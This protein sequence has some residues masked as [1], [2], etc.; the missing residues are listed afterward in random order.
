M[1]ISRPLL[2][3]AGVN[4]TAVM[5]L[6]PDLEAPRTALA[7]MGLVTVPAMAVT[8]K[9][10]TEAAVT[11][12]VVTTPTRFPVARMMLPRSATTLAQELPPL[13][14]PAP[15]FWHS[16]Q[17]CFCSSGLIVS[18]SCDRRLYPCCGIYDAASSAWMI[19]FRNWGNVRLRRPGKGYFIQHLDNALLRRTSE[20]R[21]A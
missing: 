15:W 7:V 19:G 16:E 5:G 12:A 11:E 1:L 9:A 3:W 10:A 6:V 4:R 21:T 8:R 13:P 2:P 20:E 18:S 14:C 17:R